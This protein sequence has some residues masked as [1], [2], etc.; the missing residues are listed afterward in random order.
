MTEKQVLQELYALESLDQPELV[1]GSR[2]K[3]NESAP[4]YIRRLN[5][6]TKLIERLATSCVERLQALQ[7]IGPTQHLRG[8]DAGFDADEDEPRFIKVEDDGVIEAVVNSITENTAGLAEFKENER[9][10]GRLSYYALQ[11]RD[12]KGRLIRFYRAMPIGQRLKPAEGIQAVLKKNQFVLV[13]SESVPVTF[14][15]EFT[16]ALYQGHLYI[17]GTRSFE[18]MFHYYDDLKAVAATTLDDVH[19]NH[20]PIEDFDE[21]KDRLLS[22]KANIKRLRGITKRGHLK[23]YS[24]QS[25]KGSIDRFRLGIKVTEGADGKPHLHWEDGQETEVLRLLNDYYVTSPTSGLDYGSNNKELL[26][27]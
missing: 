24:L 16:C 11:G 10:N 5:S 7:A 12:K 20:I 17:F 2:H 6:S 13:D 1:F 3:E 4:F 14:S 18:T 9:G 26:A 15:A 23:K 22:N 25:I 8:Y 21:L 27:A 19:Q